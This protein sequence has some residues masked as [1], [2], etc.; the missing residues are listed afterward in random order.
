MK[1]TFRMVIELNIGL[2][3]CVNNGLSVQSILS[4]IDLKDEL[5]TTVEKYNKALGDIMSQY[6]VEKISGKYSWVG[7]EKQKEISSKIEELVMSEVDIKNFNCLP[8]DEV[9][10][11]TSGLSI[12]AISL[13][14]KFLKK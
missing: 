2:G 9:V 4:L 14:M 6:G 13:L 10:K 7:N 8:E 1:T 5:H 3:S 11:L 12:D